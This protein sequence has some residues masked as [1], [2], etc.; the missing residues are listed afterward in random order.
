MELKN[1][2]SEYRVCFKPGHQKKF[3]EE[4]KRAIESQNSDKHWTL[5]VGEKLGK[6]FAT[7]YDYLHENH[8][9]GVREV[10]LLLEFVPHLKNEINNWIESIKSPREIHARVTYLLVEKYPREV[11]RRWAQKAGK[12]A[13]TKNLL[14]GREYFVKIGKLGKKAT[15]KK[16]RDKTCEWGKKGGLKVAM[17]Q[18]LT[19]QEKEIIRIN[20]K[21]GIKNF[22][23]H[24]QFKETVF[25]IVYFC[26]GHPIVFEE[27]TDAIPFRNHCFARVL[28]FYEKMR[29][30]KT[31]NILTPLIT[32]LRMKKES[33]SVPPEFLLMMLKLDI[34][35]IFYENKKMLRKSR[36]LIKYYLSN[37]S[38]KAN[39]I[40]SELREQV[41]KF[42]EERLDILKTRKIA[43]SMRESQ[44]SF[45]DDERRIDRII[46]EVGLKPLGKVVLRKEKYSLTTDNAFD[47]SRNRFY[48]FI[49]KIG[50]GRTAIRDKI[51]FLAG[52]CFVVKKFLEPK[53]KCIA[54]L[55]NFN[56]SITGGKWGEYL[57]R[58]ADIVTT[59]YNLKT[60]L[61]KYISQKL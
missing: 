20:K 13:G 8:R 38:E 48:V 23:T 16:Y 53:A 51:R 45:L 22:Q 18:P 43:S 24:F 55:S 5:I 56:K 35:P 25:D 12:A 33:I 47:L 32:T 42:A 41:K 39:K 58:Y 31:D 37:K 11:R 52:Y 30:L 44:T 1:F 19:T 27:I 50:N 40:I 49:T 60:E 29:L 61:E 9:L 46:R 15:Y 28:D 57:R 26:N 34:L 36:K 7:I 10:L 14:K 54:V 6:S 17:Q 3:M 21:F 4:V 2:S 59:E